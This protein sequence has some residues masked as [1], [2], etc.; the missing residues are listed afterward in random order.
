MFT[1]DKD[2]LHTCK[3]KE[4]DFM[5]IRNF[6]ISISLISMFFTACG[7]QEP[8]PQI[9]SF[10]FNGEKIALTEADFRIMNDAVYL[11]T[12]LLDKHMHLKLEELVPG[13]QI[14][15]CTDELCIPFALDKSDPQAAFKEGETFFIPIVT[16]MESLGST[17]LW[18]PESK[19]LNVAYKIRG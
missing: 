9:E 4:Y 10:V 16:L 3:I 15:I 19:T 12:T 2:E 18:N 6:L 5:N 7:S 8:G 14:G 11:A 17:A 13:M 1:Q